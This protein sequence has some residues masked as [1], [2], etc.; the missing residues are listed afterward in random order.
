M[1]VHARGPLPM[2]VAIISFNTRELLADCLQSVA[3]AAPVET[4][5]V[6]NG[7]IDGSLEMVRDRFPAVRLIANNV[8]RGYGAAANQAIA[9][10]TAPSGLLLNPDTV[11]APEALVRLGEYLAHRP[12]VAIVGPRLVGRNGAL[13]RSTYPFPGPMDTLMAEGGVHLLVRR[14]PCARERALRTW[15]H[16]RPRAVAWALGA[17]LAIRRSAFDA[18]G[19]FD[20]AYFMYGE[21]LDLCRR[22]AVRGFATHFAPVTT[23]VHIGGTST[24]TVSAAMRREFLISHARNL[25]TATGPRLGPAALALLRAIM[26]ARYLRERLRASLTPSAAA[27]SRGRQAADEI[28]ALLGERALWT[29]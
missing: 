29:L 23:V 4:V 1:T 13:Q 18:V 25:R 15:S 24:D 22:L 6:D 7:S 20:P 10:W 21:E 12:E 9:A 14:I 2:S 8:N 3:A 28:A 27:R 26:C 5:V 19:G 16:D 11:I 17:A